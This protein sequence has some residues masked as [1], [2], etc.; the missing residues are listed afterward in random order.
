MRQPKIYTL[1]LESKGCFPHMVEE[2]FSCFHLENRLK[3]IKS[4]LQENFHFVKSFKIRLRCINCFKITDDISGS[5][6]KG[7]KKMKIHSKTYNCNLDEK[8]EHEVVFENYNDENWI[9]SHESHNSYCK[10]SGLEAEYFLGATNFKLFLTGFHTQENFDF[11][12]KR[13][14]KAVIRIQIR[15]AHNGV[16]LR[17]QNFI[18][19]NGFE[20]S[21]SS[22]VYLDF[23]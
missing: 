2:Y 5:I 23:E 20:P 12:K 10:Y 19:F 1:T 17:F 6:D 14:Q 11:F 22:L 8:S 9:F 4:Y 18:D 3:E 7:S 21:Y 15:E 16:F 13:G